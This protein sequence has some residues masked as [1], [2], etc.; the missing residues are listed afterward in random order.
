MARGGRFAAV[1]LI[2]E[3]ISGVDC[4]P[5]LRRRTMKATLASLVILSLTIAIAFAA[6]E[7]A[8]E[9]GFTSLFNGK[10][11]TGWVYGQTGKGEN[12]AGAGYQVK[13]GAIYCTVKDGG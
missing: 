7:P 1:G 4:A 13:D 11:L 12:K 5:H 6:D 10:D 2:F 8:K 3:G 9:E